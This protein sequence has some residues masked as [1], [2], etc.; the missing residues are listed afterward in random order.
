MPNQPETRGPHITHNTKL[1]RQQRR[2]IGKGIMSTLFAGKT[3]TEGRNTFRNLRIVSLWR[4]T[5]HY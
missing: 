1:C 3:K 5:W 4:H 2:S